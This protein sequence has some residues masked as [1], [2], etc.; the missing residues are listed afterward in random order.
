MALLFPLLEVP[1]EVLHKSNGEEAAC[2]P[3]A[4]RWCWEG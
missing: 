2:L 3:S 1:G 4:G